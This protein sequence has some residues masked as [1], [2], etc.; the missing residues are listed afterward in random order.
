MTPPER[1]RIDPRT[2]TGI[3][4][5]DVDEADVALLGS[6]QRSRL[7]LALK[8]LLELSG[9]P[10][11]RWPRGA[12][13][14]SAASAWALLSHVQRCAPDEVEA[15]LHDP[16]VGA[17]AFQLLRQWAH[18]LAGAHDDAPPWAG[19]SLLTS[20][21]AA[22]AVR[23]GMRCSLRLP[24]RGGRLWLPSLGL[25]GVV[26]RGDWALVG[27]ESGPSGTVVY[28]DGGS[29]RLP[30][31]LSAAAEGWSPLPVVGLNWPDGRRRA[32]LDHLSPHRD[33]RAVRGPLDLGPADIQ[34]WRQVLHGSYE[35]LRRTDPAAY[36]AVA[37]TLR[38]VVPLESAGALR[39]VSASVPDA[40]GAITLSFSTDVPSMAAALVHEAR[41]QLLTA[42]DDLTPLLVPVR[43]GPEPVYF[44][45]WRTDPRPLR[46]LLYGA[47]AFAGMVSFWH[48]LRPSEGQRA[49]FEFAFCRWQLRTAL[50]ALRKA[51]HL[52]EAG[53][54][55][56]TALAEAA[57]AWW[58]A[59][60]PGPPARLAELCS[61][62]ARASWRATNLAVD[63]SALQA[64]AARWAEGRPPSS[65]LPAARMATHRPASAG[66]GALAW[67]ARL[68]LSDAEAFRHVRAGL[69]SGAIDALEMN[70][71]CAADAALVAGKH[72]EALRG[73]REALSGARSGVLPAARAC[74][75]VGLARGCEDSPLVERPEVVLA[76]HDALGQRVTEPPGPEELAEWL[77]SR[78]PA[79][80]SDAE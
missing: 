64:L 70:G 30:P 2:L 7:V 27:V 79:P 37:G 34:D 69:G 44:A 62:E 16:A 50:A 40:Y 32:V 59:P 12:P 36:R 48:R 13:P 25:T 66:G 9:H 41:H 5:G 15:V 58:P 31:D 6:A 43:E 35:V 23:A 71:A 73:Y 72:E 3:A 28:G 57:A 74:V 77:A 47:H 20:L 52:T 65:T 56:V 51:T 10:D 11:G 17:C 53:G 29:V 46:G 49:D 76:L 14:T 26:A 4:L 68:R 60:V 22:A 42:L 39:V 1:Y 33:F 75:G 78:A 19:A 54:R 55:V 67:L 18:D 38:S 8:A 21:A 24:A 61:R 63:A 80:R 45:P